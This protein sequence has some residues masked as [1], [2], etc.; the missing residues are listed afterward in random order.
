MRERN[1]RLYDYFLGPLRIC[2]APV[3]AKVGVTILSSVLPAVQALTTAAFVDMALA[4]FAGR[5]GAEA[6]IPSLLVLLVLMLYDNLSGTLGQ[7]LT[8]RIRL[9][10][11]RACRGWALEQRAALKYW[12]V[13]DNDTWD[14]ITRTADKLPE[15]M[16][17]GF[18]SLVQLAGIVFQI[19][20]VMGIVFA[21]AWWIG[22]VMLACFVPLLFLALKGGK[23]TYQGQVEA[24]RHRRRAD[25]LAKVLSGRESVEERALFGYGGEIN[26]EWYEKFE[27]ARKTQLKVD[28]KYFI[29]MKSGSLAAVAFTTLICGLLLAPVSRGSMTAGAFIGLLTALGSLY[30]LLS[31]GLAY[32][33]K[34]MANGR[35]FLKD[36]NKFLALERQ[37]DAL[38]LPAGGE[39]LRLLEFDHV[40]FRYPGSEHYILKGFCLSVTPGLHYAFV[41][42]NGAGKT[43]VTKLLTGMFDYEGSIRLN[44]KELREIPLPKRKAMFS[45][46]YQDFARYQISL[47]ENIRLGDAAHMDRD[48][49]PA[50]EQAGLA[51]RI[52][53][54]PRGIAT[55][56]GKA[57]EG[58]VDLSGGEW[59]R[60]AIARALQSPAPVR[61]LDEP[62][63]ALDPMAESRVYETFGEMS[64]GHTTIFIT[65]RLGAARL[66]DTI[67]VLDEGRAAELG[68]HNELIA[69]GGI[70]ARMFESQRS[71]Y[72]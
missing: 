29:R 39:E 50:A 43:T 52:A 63:A 32:Y 8:D 55:D 58:G 9:Q 15:R 51:E 62:T 57:R 20:S 46:V 40:S 34:E 37:E 36:V 31:W 69:L 5:V 65:H 13:E 53:A 44:G 48:A 23:A 3:L 67:V 2:P 19:V 66:A 42:V 7:L 16:R 21:Q 72:Q 45:V 64:K 70:Y 49:L 1:C 6:L 38:A 35:E 14:L 22:A 24:E 26:R 47:E 41:G 59:Q 30:S 12:Y 27:Q 18:D 4:L 11:D 10:V 33:A 61:I 68:S 28:M 54:L 56:L 25:Y 71:W 60:A 17:I